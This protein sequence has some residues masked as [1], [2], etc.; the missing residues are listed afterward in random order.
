MSVCEYAVSARLFQAPLRNFIKMFPFF[1]L[2]TVYQG[3]KV[4]FYNRRHK[5]LSRQRN[6]P[7][8]QETYAKKQKK[9]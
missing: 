1:S 2:E 3:S 8:R 9:E 4:I 5:I 7:G 6:L